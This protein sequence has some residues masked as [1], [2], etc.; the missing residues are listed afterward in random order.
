VILYCDTSALVKLL[1]R[2]EG[3]ELVETLWGSAYPVVT[4]ILAYPEG[5]SALG[6][7]RRT[8]RLGQARY[9]RALRAFDKLYEELVLVGVDEELARVAGVHVTEF[10]LRGYDAVHL[11]TALD[12]AEEEVMF[13][14]W[15]RNL[16]GAADSA[17]LATAGALDG[18][19]QA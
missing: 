17:G 2:E 6:V 7:A 3:S 10:G 8:G 18:D 1:I 19:D 14:T 5:R 4:S 9:E 15:D 13:V 16:A 12:L 11:A